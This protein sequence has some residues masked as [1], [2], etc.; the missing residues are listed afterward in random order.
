M[1]RGFYLLTWSKEGVRDW[2]CCWAVSLANQRATIQPGNTFRIAILRLF[3]TYLR[4]YSCRTSTY[5]GTQEDSCAVGRLASA[6]RPG[7]LF[8]ALKAPGPSGRTGQGALLSFSDIY[9]P[10]QLITQEK[11]WREEML[12]ALEADAPRNS[13]AERLCPPSRRRL[14]QK[15]GMRAAITNLE[16][17]RR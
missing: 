6:G 8:C 5:N 12:L 15:C 4:T 7:S 16:A 1:S 17:S 11:P 14:G 3:T 2:E 10:I 13:V 9:R